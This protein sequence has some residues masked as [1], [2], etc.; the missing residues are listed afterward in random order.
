MKSKVK[1]IL[2]A[3]MIVLC[4]CKKKDCKKDGT[5]PPEFYRYKLGEAERYLGARTGSYWIY[6]DT[7]T[8]TLDTQFCTGYYLDS[9]T[10][11]GNQVFSKH[12]TVTYDQLFFDISTS[13]RK[14]VYHCS[15]NPFTANAT[16]QGYRIILDRGIG[17][18][19]VECFFYP[20][21]LGIHA[22]TYHTTEC[23]GTDSTMVVQGKTY[24]EVVKFKISLDGSWEEGGLPLFTGSIYYWAKDVGLIRREGI[25][26]PG[27]WE[28]IDYKIIK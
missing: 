2:I 5:C 10:T 28:L 21:D 17:G 7:F 15:T 6:K 3:T 25:H 20:F 8:G 14:S 23:L 4:T 11:K 12:V 24:R 22:G 26:K 19:G 13:S 27:N 9:I 1:F 18:S 16:T